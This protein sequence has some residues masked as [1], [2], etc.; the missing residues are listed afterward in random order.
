MHALAKV[1]VTGNW[2]LADVTHLFPARARHFIAPIMLHEPFSARA[3]AYNSCRHGFLLFAHAG[4]LFNSARTPAPWLLA[5]NAQAQT[6][7]RAQ[8][9]LG[10]AC[11]CVHHVPARTRYER[12]RQYGRSLQ[13]YEFN[14]MQSHY[15][16]QVLVSVG[17][18]AF[19]CAFAHSLVLTV[20]RP[21]HVLV[22]APTARSV[23]SI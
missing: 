13:L 6:A 2:N 21:M 18:F 23:R 11:I 5:I 12:P 9:R 10:Q 1:V 15:E 20:Q 7:H 17:A 16:F 4:V 3:L 19:C 8:R 14:E 22:Q